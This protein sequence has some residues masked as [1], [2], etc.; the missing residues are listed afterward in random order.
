MLVGWSVGWSV[1]P[2]VCPHITSKTG[3]VAI[4]SGLGFG[5]NLVFMVS[6]ACSIGINENVEHPR[7]KFSYGS[8]VW[9]I[10]DMLVY[11]SVRADQDYALIMSFTWILSY[12]DHFLECRVKKNL[13][14]I[15]LGI[16]V[17]KGVGGVIFSWQ[18]NAVL[19]LKIS[20]VG[21]DAKSCNL[22]HCFCLFDIQIFF[23]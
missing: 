9:T 22:S 21:M 7:R 1:S 10:S 18:K 3:Y 2:S 19:V 15:I 17:F 12:F 6:Y 8:W 13:T 5:N 23:F 11:I 16:A 14:D 4:T 20:L